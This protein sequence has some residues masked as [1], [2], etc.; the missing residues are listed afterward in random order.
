M[1]S[2]YLPKRALKTEREGAHWKLGVARWGFVHSRS[3]R[4]KK[5]DVSIRKEKKPRRRK[6]SFM[7]TL[8]PEYKIRI[9]K[10]W[11]GKLHF[12]SLRDES[13][14]VLIYCGRSENKKKTTHGV[15]CFWDGIKRTAQHDMSWLVLSLKGW[16]DELFILL[17][18]FLK[19]SW[20][21]SIVVDFEIFYSVF[22]D[23]CWCFSTDW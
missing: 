16:R 1:S 5:V 6:E 2:K 8:D 10:P 18:S 17:E 21:L 7:L 23:F 9:E 13:R 19:A 22:L 11:W 12:F 3:K 4:K 14:L 20:K 15:V